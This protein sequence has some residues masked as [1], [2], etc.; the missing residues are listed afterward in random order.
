MALSSYVY[1]NE[2]GEIAYLAGLIN[3]LGDM[4]SLRLEKLGLDEGQ[5]ICLDVFKGNE[6]V[7]EEELK[8]RYK[9]I[10][11]KEYTIGSSLEKEKLDI[12]KMKIKLKE[13]DEK[14]ED[15]LYIC[16]NKMISSK[17]LISLRQLSKEIAEDIILYTEKEFSK[18]KIFKVFGIQ[19]NDFTHAYDYLG[20]L[21]NAY[22]MVNNDISILFLSG[23]DD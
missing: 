16:F 14:M 21:E 1:E 2:N 13:V 4:Y 11:E 3:M 17:G 12:E 10:N 6:L 20:R 7:F 23:F 8:K 5:L 9:K 15:I 22:L 19:N 18:I